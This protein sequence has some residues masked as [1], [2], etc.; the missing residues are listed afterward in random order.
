MRG[1]RRRKSGASSSS[2][3]LREPNEL[4]RLGAELVAALGKWPTGIYAGWYPIKDLA[5]VDRLAAWVHD[6]ST[7]PVL[8]L[9]LLVDD[10]VRPVAAE[11][12]RASRP[13]SALPLRADSEVCCRRLPGA[14]RRGY[15]AFR[16]GAGPTGLRRLWPRNTC[17]IKLVFQGPHAHPPLLSGLAV[18]PEG[19]DQRFPPGPRGPDRSGRRRHQ[20]SGRF[21]AGR[22]RSA[23][24]RRCCWRAARRSTIPA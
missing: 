14:F 17:A 3:P 24:S 19:Q 16:C 13:Q 2:V 7:R 18:R 1:F 9:E 10:P 4:E 5:P 8:R 12:Q 23:R 11:R 6:R 20:R 21:Y 22:T 15:A